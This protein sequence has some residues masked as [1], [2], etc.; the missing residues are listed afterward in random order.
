MRIDLKTALFAI[1]AVAAFGCDDDDD[2]GGAG[3]GADMMVGAGGE[4]G[5]GGMP[6]CVEDCDEDG[7]TVEQGDCND[8]DPD[9]FPGAPDIC[10]NIDN[11]CDRVI[12]GAVMSCYTGPADTLGVGP[13]Q[14]GVSTCE[15]G[16]FGVCE[17]E[18]TPAADETCGDGIDDDCDGTADEGC[19]LDGDGVTPED[20]DCDDNEPAAFPGN[21]EVCDNIDNDCD[22]VIDGI[23][24]PCYEGPPGTAGVGICR[25]G[26]RTCNAGVFADCADQVQPGNEACDNGQDDD[27]DG[28]VDE[29]CNLIGCPDL[30]LDSPVVLGSTCLAV[31]SGARA[32][33]YAEVRDTNGAIIPDATVEIQARGQ[34]GL[35]PLAQIGDRWWR[36]INTPPG[37]GEVTFSVLVSCGDAAPVALNTQPR[38]SNVAGLANGQ[39]MATG[40]CDDPDGNLEIA[41]VDADSGAPINGAVF[42]IGTAPDTLYQRAAGRHVRGDAGNDPNTGTTGADGKG[43]LIDYGDNLNGPQTVTV[44][45]EG[46][47]YVTL[48]GLSA[49]QARVA[50]RRVDPPAPETVSLNGELSQY[51]DLRNDGQT[52]AGVVLG[53]FDI[54]GLST[55]GL[56]DLLG[57]FECWDPVIEPGLIGDTVDEVPTP[58]NL[59]VPAQQ[60]SV[61][62]FPVNINPHPFALPDFP[63]GRDNLVAA[64]GKLPTDDLTALLLN[65]GSLADT[66]SLLTLTEIGVLRNQ[67]FDADRPNMTIPLDTDLNANASC[68][69]AGVPA[70]GDLFCVVAGDWGGGMGSGDL[71]PMGLASATAED[72]AN[73]GDRVELTMTTVPSAGAFNGIGYVSAAVARF[74]NDQAPPAI[75]GAISSIINRGAIDGMGGEARYDGFFAPTGLARMDRTFNWSRVGTPDSPSV[76]MC[77]VDVLRSIRTLYQPGPCVEGNYAEI[78]EAPVW[79]VMSVGDTGQVT[80]P[81]IPDDWPRART[82]GYVNPGATP[83]DDRLQMRVRCMGLGALPDFD[84]DAADFSAVPNGV[85]HTSSILRNF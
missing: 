43:R 58:G 69:V 47:E 65:G 66:I 83:E 32:T 30:D 53:S 82:F 1:L 3:G 64:S 38:L 78:R 8:E 44:G 9:I 85:T 73:A 22:R 67:D 12:D 37:P 18:V 5:M 61:F 70:Q 40:G 26:N 77:E 75:R 35:E 60:E 42:M 10:D 39:N 54:S 4:G 29:N 14:Q 36:R 81:T 71:F 72:V 16:E 23:V 68:S 46:Y 52:D 48:V 7:I 76:D 55:F 2:T 25:E 28:A 34:A 19:D 56:N 33:I 80:L 6:P 17:G 27:C 74:Q 63:R 51:N 79:R 31:G 20:G 50:L 57:R 62:G 49:S 84:F 15:A 59:V 13:C 45:A 21:P 24:E 11:D 41:A